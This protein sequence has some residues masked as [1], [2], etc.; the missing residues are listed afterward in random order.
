[1]R[2]LVIAV[3]AC[4]IVLSLD[5]TRAAAQGRV[6]DAG[7]VAVGGSVGVSFPSDGRLNQG[8]DVALNVEGYLTPRVSIRGQVG[9]SWWD[10]VGQRFGGTLNPFYIDGNLVYNWEGGKVHPY[11]TGGVGAY[12]YRWSETGVAD[13]GK[14]AVGANLGGGLEFF[15]TRHSTGTVEVLYHAVGQVIT[16]LLPLDKGSFWTAAAGLKHYF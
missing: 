2:L 15:F 6:P 1:M 13:G 14:T 10:I 5:V 3:F 11:V 8:F 4:A 9:G 16:P 7:M 12:R